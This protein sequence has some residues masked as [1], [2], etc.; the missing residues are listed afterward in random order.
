MPQW[1]QVASGDRA[2]KRFNNPQDR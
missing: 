2:I 1:V